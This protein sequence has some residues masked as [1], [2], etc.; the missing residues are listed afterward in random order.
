MKIGAL[1]KQSGCGAET[2]RYYEQIGLLVAPQ[3]NDS[4]YRV[5]GQAHLDRLLFI[6]HCRS[7]DMS[8]EEIR[9]LLALRDA[10][11]QGCDQVNTL[12]ERHIDD[13]DQRIAALTDLRQRMSSLRQQCSGDHDVADCGIIQGLST[14]EACEGGHAHQN[15]RHAAG[16]ATL[17]D[18]NR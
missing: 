12:L 4:N 6:R 13:I 18:A 9:A 11:R 2:I 15:A 10:P 16:P 7:L 5:Y 3:R 17:P 8:L 1:A 14:C